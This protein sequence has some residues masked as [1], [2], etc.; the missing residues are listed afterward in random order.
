MVYILL[1]EQGM[2][3]IG[4]QQTS[5]GLFLETMRQTVRLMISKLIERNIISKEEWESSY[6]TEVVD[7]VNALRDEIN[8][9]IQQQI[10]QENKDVKV[11]VKDIVS[12]KEEIDC[13]AHTISRS[14]VTLPSERNNV[15][16]F[17]SGKKED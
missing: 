3:Q 16:V 7:K 10:E 14:E 4:N 8:K 1:E 6:K 15:I 11:E 5:M 12:K 17:P 13:E 9:K 2:M